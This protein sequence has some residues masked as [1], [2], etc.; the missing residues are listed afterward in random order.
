MGNKGSGIGGFLLGGVIGAGLGLLFAPRSGRETREFIADRAL[1]YWEYGEEMYETGVDRAYE[2][3]EQ[4]LQRATEV[5]AQVR[6]KLDD[7]RE[8][9]VDV[10]QAAKEEFGIAVGG[11]DTIAETIAEVRAEGADAVEAA[12]EAGSDVVSEAAKKVADAVAPNPA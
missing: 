4:G 12:G 8:R 5:S 1:E 6:E 10:A 3:Y 11:K 2:T 9:L 7:T